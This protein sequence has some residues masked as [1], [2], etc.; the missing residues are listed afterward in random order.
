MKRVYITLIILILPL[1]NVNAQEIG[2]IYENISEQAESEDGTVS[3]NNFTEWEELRT[4]PLDLNKADYEQLS[5]FP[6]LNESQILAFLRYR[7]LHGNLLSLNE[8]LSIEGFTIQTFGQLLPFVALES[9]KEKL[10]L[11]H[12]KNQLLTRWQQSLDKANGFSSYT[13]RYGNI[14][15]PAFAGDAHKMLLKYRYKVSDKFSAGFTLEKDA[16]EKWLISSNLPDF[17]SAHVFYKPEKVL[18]TIVIGDYNARFGQG[19]VLWNGF[20]QGKSLYSSNVAKHQRGISPF[21]GTEENRFF[22]GIA[23]EWNLGNFRLTALYSNKN[24]DASVSTSDSLNNALTLSS[25]GSSGSHATESEI[26]NR[27]LVND[28]TEAINLRYNG[29]HFEMGITGAARQLSLP[30]DASDDPYRKFYFAGKN[31]QVAS[32]DYRLIVSNL[33]LFG[34]FAQSKPGDWALLQGLSYHPSPSISTS[35]IYRNYQPGY[36]GIMSAAFGENDNA[37]NEEGLYAG[38][39]IGVSDKI[40]VAGY[41]DLFRFPWLR[42]RVDAPSVGNDYLLNVNYQINTQWQLSGQYKQSLRQQNS[43]AIRD[44]SAL[45]NL[46]RNALRMSL[47]YPISDFISGRISGYYNQYHFEMDDESGYFVYNDLFFS[48]KQDIRISMRTGYF[49]TGSYNS[50]VYAYEP[51]MPWTF[52]VSSLYGRGYRGAIVLNIKSIRCLSVYLK[53]SLTYYVNERPESDSYWSSESQIPSDVGVML[54][55]RF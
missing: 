53:Y 27:H 34:E 50:R 46:S 52:G 7:E 13:D 19:L 8:L 45:S 54:S 25:L 17:S 4:N 6:F 48:I 29:L 36:C 26:R 24:R 37:T 47:I 42:Y 38:A 20:S 1:L 10:N 15:P 35:L 2:Q 12:G 33:R 23:S 5:I 11:K 3:E 21:T 55:W 44:I 39:E 40:K 30:I 49:E 16:G 9:E 14:K 43:D 51:N 31:L 28:Q 22:R 32:A 18:N 41:I